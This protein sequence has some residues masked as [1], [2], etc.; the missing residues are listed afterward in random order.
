VLQ[1]LAYHGLVAERLD[2]SIVRDARTRL[3]RW[4]RDSRIDPRWANE[5]DGI[6]AL[7]LSRIAKAI[8]A[9]SPKARALR[10]TSPFAGVL[11]AQER[12]RLVRAVEERAAR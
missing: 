8:S 12:R 5:W 4:R 9:D 11:T 10:Q 1:S 6:L 7:P 3:R 2:D